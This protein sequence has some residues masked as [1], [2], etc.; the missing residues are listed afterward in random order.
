MGDEGLRIGGETDRFFWD[1]DLV[2][3]IF[4]LQ[5]FQRLSWDKWP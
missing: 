5:L 3:P 1:K 4:S 2:R